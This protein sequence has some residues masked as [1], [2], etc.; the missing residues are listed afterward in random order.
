MADRI[1]FFSVLTRSAFY[2]IDCRC[3]QVTVLKCPVWVFLTGSAPTI[4]ETSLFLQSSSRLA[5]YPYLWAPWRL[6]SLL[7]HSLLQFPPLRPPLL[8]LTLPSLPAQVIQANAT[9]RTL[10]AISRGDVILQ[11]HVLSTKAGA[12]SSPFH[13]PWPKGCQGPPPFSCLPLLWVC[14]GLQPNK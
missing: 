8:P 1:L 2:N 13:S 3:S 6:Q 7:Y 14:L 5:Q 10:H 12:S 11:F 4:L 9:S